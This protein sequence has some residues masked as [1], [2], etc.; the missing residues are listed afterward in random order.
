MKKH[1]KIITMMITLLF[2]SLILIHCSSKINKTENVKVISCRVLTG[3]ISGNCDNGYGKFIYTDGIEYLGFWKEGKRDGYGTL[4]ITN[5][6]ISVDYTNDL[7][8]GIPTSKTNEKNYYTQTLENKNNRKEI[9]IQKHDT[10]V[11]DAT[12][13]AMSGFVKVSESLEYIKEQNE[14]Q[15]RNKK[16]SLCDVK[17]DGYWKNNKRH[18]QSKMTNANCS[19]VKGIWEDDILKK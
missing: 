18:G 12:I 14:A 11:I 9:D 3:C 4:T 19:E 8:N 1:T 5:E 13:M 16:E 2:V 17:Y 6:P 7:K 10:N 15:K